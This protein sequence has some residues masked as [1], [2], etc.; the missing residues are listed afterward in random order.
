MSIESEISSNHLI[1]CWL[2]SSCPW[3]FPVSESFPVSLLFT[4]GAQRT[5]ASAT[6]LRINIQDWFTLGLTSL[7]EIAV[8]GTLKNLLWIHNSKASILCCSAFFMVQLSHPYMTTGNTHTHTHT[9]LW[10][11]RHLLAKWYLFFLICYLDLSQSSPPPPP[12]PRNKCLLILLLQ[13]PSPVILEPNKMKFV[14]AST[15]PPSFAMK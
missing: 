9:Q 5:G 2:F 1:L 15:F 12:A 3:S 13:S 14:T 7:M 6:V 8:Q 10:L 4:S 11:Y